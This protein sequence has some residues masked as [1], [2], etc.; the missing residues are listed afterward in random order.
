[1]MHFHCLKMYRNAILRQ[2]NENEF[3]VQLL[4]KS[5]NQKINIPFLRL[6]LIFLNPLMGLQ[7][8][9]HIYTY[10]LCICIIHFMYFG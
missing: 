3:K 9:S 6:E 1:M 5:K 10:N 2:K 7:K 8:V 4:K